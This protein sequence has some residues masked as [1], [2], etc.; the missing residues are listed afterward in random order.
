MENGKA[1]RESES[2]KRS[3]TEVQKMLPQ[4]N[5]PL[6]TASL[7]PLHPPVGPLHVY[8]VILSF[9]FCHSQTHT[10]PDPAAWRASCAPWPCPPA[11]FWQLET[12]DSQGDPPRHDDIST[13]VCVDVTAASSAPSLRVHAAAA[14]RQGIL[15]PSHTR[16]RSVLLPFCLTTGALTSS[17]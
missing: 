14:M 8:D 17:V 9:L 2:G 12:D 11:R 1:A 3:R 5:T 15:L 10:A 13:L 6:V 16:S 7:S 4:H